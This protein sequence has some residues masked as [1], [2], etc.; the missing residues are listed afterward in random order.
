MKVQL[1]KKQTFASSQPAKAFLNDLNAC[2]R[3]NVATPEFSFFY[4][5]YA[6][7][8]FWKCCRSF[9]NQNSIHEC[10]KVSHWS[11][12]KPE[13]KHLAGII[14]PSLRIRHM[15]LRGEKTG[16]EF[17]L[18]NIRLGAQFVFLI[19]AIWKFLTQKATCASLDQTPRIEKCKRETIK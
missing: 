5:Q 13:K 3:L 17:F 18:L 7:V 8:E 11:G 2:H 16:Y 10:I 14:K 12:S 15:V 9:S 1:A 4:V 19:S 6:V